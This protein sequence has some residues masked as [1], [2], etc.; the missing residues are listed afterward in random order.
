MQVQAARA[1]GCEYGQGYVFAQPLPAEAISPLLMA[2]APR[3]VD[4]A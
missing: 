4:V 1:L 2:T 3:H